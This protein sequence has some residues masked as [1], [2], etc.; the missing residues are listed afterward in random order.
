MEACVKIGDTVA[1]IQ[2]GLNAGMWTIGLTKTGNELGL[3]ELEVEALPVEEL[4]AR[5]EAIK[6]RFIRT[7]AHYVVEGIW[8]C[9]A[10]IEEIKPP[11][12]PRAGNLW[13]AERIE[14]SLRPGRRTGGPGTSVHGNR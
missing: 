8:D 9:P 3:P 4:Q 11:F 1:D 10:I 2:E 6:N 5:L 12:W 13:P 14:D 7:G